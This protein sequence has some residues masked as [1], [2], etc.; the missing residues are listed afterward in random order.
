[1]SLGQV[2]LGSEGGE[3]RQ[4]TL[5]VLVRRQLATDQLKSR[6]QVLLRQLIDQV[7]QLLPDSA[8]APK[9]TGRPPTG[10]RE[11]LQSAAV[12]CCG[13][14]TTVRRVL[15]SKR[16]G[17]IFAPGRSG[18]SSMVDRGGVE[19][20]TFRFSGV[21]SALLTVLVPRSDGG[22]RVSAVAGGCCRCC[23]RC[24]QS[25]RC[26][27]GR[28]RSQ[29]GALIRLAGPEPRRSY[30]AEPFRVIPCI[31]VPPSGKRARPY[32]WRWSSLP[33]ERPAPIGPGLLGFAWDV[34]AGDDP[35]SAFPNGLV[36]NRGRP[37]PSQRPPPE[38]SRAMT[39]DP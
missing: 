18:W 27:G 2:R 17:A 4:V 37:S 32:G 10:Q 16:P 26:S 30:T 7:V 3:E 34:G 11:R 8:H 33:E 35:G 38:A 25:G 5:V 24:C 6:A 12:R 29:T 20:P 39:F 9:S 21:T 15:S 31:V 23:H 1:M 14:G 28:R 19:P 36:R 22:G 13:A